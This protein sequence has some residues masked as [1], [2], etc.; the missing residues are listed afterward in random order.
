MQGGPSRPAASP[1]L[2]PA[3]FAQVPDTAGRGRPAL[4]GRASLPERVDARR[5]QRGDEAIEAGGECVG[6]LEEGRVAAGK[7]LEAC[8]A[9]PAL[10]ARARATLAGLPLR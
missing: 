8:V 10:G 5:R 6:V 1:V 9:D 3:A 7:D 4:N 2:G